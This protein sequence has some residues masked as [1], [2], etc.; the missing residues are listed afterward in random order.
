MQ[1]SASAKPLATVS[2][3]ETYLSQGIPSADSLAP[4][5]LD[6]FSQWFHLAQSRPDDVPEPEA[7]SLSTVDAETHIPSTRVV[8]LKQVDPRGF[9]FYTNYSSRKGRELF[10]DGDYEAESPRGAY[11]SLAF[12]W[13]K[14]HLSV[15]VVGRV[16]RVDRA[17]TQAYFDSRPVGSRIGAWASDQSSVLPTGSREELEQRVRDVERRFG[18]PEGT[19]TGSAVDVGPEGKGS[20][21]QETHIPVPPFWGGIR[22]VP[23]EVEFWAGRESRLHDR[24]RYT[25]KEGDED[26]SWKIERLCP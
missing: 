19:A 25:R 4:N 7:M 6:Q 20:A 10:P 13:R 18:V 15:R 22:V 11:A 17:T 2:N 23:F 24:Y 3:H 8:L 21:A 14:L 5:P 9:V 12:Y 26:A 16:E 1:A